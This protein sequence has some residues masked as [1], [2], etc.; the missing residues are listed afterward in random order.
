MVVRE[1]VNKIGFRIDE[2]ALR[3]A[4]SRMNR[5]G[6]QMQTAGLKMS[7]AFTLPLVL[8]GKRITTAFTGF[9]D[10][11]LFLQSRIKLTADE[12]KLLSNRALELAK[13][14]V[15]TAAETADAMNNLG[16]AGFNVNKIYGA[17]PGV[18]DLA[19][20]SNMDMAETA[21]VASG[22]I[23]SFSL[24][25]EEA[26]R[27]AD[28][29]TVASN[30]AATNLPELSQA[31]S[32]AGG[33][34]AGF[35]NNLEETLAILGSFAKRQI[36][37]TRAGTSLRMALLNLAKPTP[38]V[39]R[40]LER[41]GVRVKD[42][43][44]EMLPFIDILER[45]EKAQVTTNDLTH[46]FGTRALAAV[47][48][49][50]AT[51]TPRLREMA[52]IMRTDVGA[53]ARM[54]SARLSG[55]GGAMRKLASKLDVLFIKIAKS[56]FAKV[57]G[58]MVTAAG[59]L[60]DKLAELNPEMLNIIVTL[61]VLLAAIGPVLLGLSVMVKTMAFVAG[62]M[63]T[64]KAAFF[65]AAGA[66]GAFNASLLVIPAI[67]LAIIALIAL[68][69]EDFL[70]WTKGGDSLIGR[71][72][73][74]FDG[75]RKDLKAILELNIKDFREWQDALGLTMDH[76]KNDMANMVTGMK[77]ILNGLIEFI[78]GAFS[79]NL[80]K[81]IDGVKKIIQGAGEL[82]IP[83]EQITEKEREKIK[84]KGAPLFFKGL[85]EY[86][87][88]SLETPEGRAAA[89]KQITEGL[90]F[91]LARFFEGAA[92]QPQMVPQ[93]AGIPGGIAGGKIFHTKQDFKV[94]N[95][96]T[97]NAE[98]VTSEETVRDI[99]DKVK[100]GVEEGF[101]KQARIIN[102]NNPVVE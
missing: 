50:L 93:F 58:K 99:E 61:A 48:A 37:A 31:L 23:N 11:M 63:V 71:L 84:K 64:L 33:V 77:F 5:V 57:L 54:A 2:S 32:F 98:G 46:L 101:S 28:S 69:V 19:A 4:Q 16:A 65:G 89:E 94:E 79:L 20:A 10:A 26:T 86:T 17:T 92:R 12:F 83:G 38:E 53:A 27:V 15:F 80:E 56:G 36:T 51:G 67:I 91:K 90:F 47:Q 25:A 44:G 22:A 66:A 21:R 3:K 62:A 96:I 1:L 59:K 43:T 75:M 82:F 45:L 88:K 60:V 39:T 29:L 85:R 97:V 81:A 6:Q 8:L 41:L 9:E 100:K 13:N 30:L 95:N 52:E 18:M 34:A 72:V 76:V 49:A 74:G 102:A 78:E 40:T 68:L 87:V 14:S 42:S 35:N 73:G 7:A 24:T 55:L 70:V